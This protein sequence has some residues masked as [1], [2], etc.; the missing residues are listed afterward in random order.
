MGEVHYRN[1]YSNFGSLN[2]KY[3]FTIE[4][5]LDCKAILASQTVS[6]ICLKLQ[7][8]KLCRCDFNEDKY[9]QRST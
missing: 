1:L 2:T 6:L 8:Y 7:L 9:I 4:R 5:N 3:C